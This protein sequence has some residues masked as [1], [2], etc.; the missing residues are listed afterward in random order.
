M[1]KAIYIFFGLFS[2]FGVSYTQASVVKDDEK[3]VVIHIP[4][5]NCQ[6]CVYLV[7][8][9]LRGVNGV[10]STKANFKRQLVDIVAKK[11]VDNKLL[12]AAIDKLNYTPVIQTEE[13]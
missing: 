1:K 13:P 12:L 3:Q 6:L 2:I 7:N 4:E 5:M 9:E 10:I 11:S 8:K